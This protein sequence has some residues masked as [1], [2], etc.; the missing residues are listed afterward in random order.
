MLV[1]AVRDHIDLYQ[2]GSQT[3]S[4]TEVGILWRI[5]V[6]PM[7]AYVKQNP[8]PEKHNQSGTMHHIYCFFSVLFCL[9][10][11]CLTASSPD[12]PCHLLS[13]ALHPSLAVSGG[14]RLYSPL[15]SAQLTPRCCGPTCSRNAGQFRTGRAGHL[16]HTAGRGRPEGSVVVL[17]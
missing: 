2:S 3:C 1:L 4:Y 17:S 8:K 12:L 15:P 16:A 10:V 11:L 7:A 14:E 13:M 5:S 6:L 9:F